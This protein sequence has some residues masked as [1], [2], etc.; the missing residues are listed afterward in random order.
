V[1]WNDLVTSKLR[2]RSGSARSEATW[3]SRGAKAQGLPLL[4]WALCACSLDFDIAGRQFACPPELTG[5]LECNP[6]GSCRV[7]AVAV[8]IEPAPV[9]PPPEQPELPV[10]APDAGRAA[11]AGAAEPA[12][13]SPSDA[14]PPQPIGPL[15]PEECAE[16]ESRTS[17]S[18]CLNG[19]ERCFSLG[20]VLGPA[21]ALWLDPST[22]PR[23]GARAWCDRSGNGH[24]ALLMPKGAEPLVEE[25][26][27]TV[28]DGL[29]RSITLDGGW[30]MLKD[31]ADAVLGP[32]NFAVLLAAATPLSASDRNGPVLFESG[33]G[34]RIRLSIES[35][36]GK[37]TGS[38]SSTET[39]LVTDPVVTESSV[40]DGRF[41][42]HTL[43]RR[44][45]R[46]LDDVLQLRLNGVLEFRGSSIAIPRALDLS[47]SPG[48]RFGS[49]SEPGGE[50]AAGRGR[51]A[52]VVILRGSLPEDELAR[53]ENFLCESL[54]VCEAPGPPLGVDPTPLDGGS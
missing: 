2:T 23:D 37:A 44:S 26:F 1:P 12:P 11:D 6:D 36:T 46:V 49:R 38:I 34:S 51:L 24:H 27:R 39:A 32:G 7:E 31:G 22:L 5:C 8:P 28:G 29:G 14:A 45:V 4:A 30:L 48:P 54:A 41:H 18:L 19:S 3:R 42:L 33:D 17:D 43:Y 25:D 13:A 40:Y 15:V 50:A 53:L 10:R 21:L 47:S 52:A 16:F 20:N 35:D 9:P